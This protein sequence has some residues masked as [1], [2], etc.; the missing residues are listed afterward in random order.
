MKQK[1]MVMMIAMLI[2][3]IVSISYAKEGVD[4][5][6]QVAVEET[7][8]HTL[9]NEYFLKSKTERDTALAGSALNQDLVTIKNYPS[10][11]LQLKLVGI[12][13]ILTGIFIILIG[14]LFALMMMPIRLG[15]IIKER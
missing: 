2:L 5:H 11:L 15:Q 3:I 13:K 10:T 9:Q 7:A 6:N 14:I 8:F 1:K 4:M 12:G